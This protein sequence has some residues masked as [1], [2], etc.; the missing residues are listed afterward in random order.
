MEKKAGNGPNVDVDR[1]VEDL[2]AVV[3]D[4]QALLRAG[5]GT[6]KEQMQVGAETTG[7]LVRERPY[8]TLGMVFG[9]GVIV[10][11]LASGMFSR[12]ED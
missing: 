7:R 12:E 3:R 9:A 10:G 1:F 8:Y 4:G 2:K 6:V 11:L 5:V